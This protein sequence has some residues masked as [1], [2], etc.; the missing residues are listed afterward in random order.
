MA[1]PEY[2]KYLQLYPDAEMLDRESAYF[3]LGDC[4]R[5]MG[6]TNAAKNAYQNLLLNFA[7]GQF[8]GPAAY[9]LADMDYADKDYDGA[10]DYYRK[11]SVRLDDP[12]MVL[13][14]K[15][16]AARCLE[17]LKLPTDARMAYEDIVSTSGDNPYR[18]PSRLALAEILSTYG[19]KS[20]ALDQFLALAKEAKQPVVKAESYLEAGLLDVNDLDEPEKGAVDL[21][22]ALSYPE[23]GDE[24]P[25]A[26][27]GLLRVLAKEGKYKQ[28]LDQ[29]QTALD[30]VGADEKPQV[31]SLAADAKHQ[32]NDYAG[33]GALYDQIL[34]DYPNTVYSDEANVDK[35]VNLYYAKDPSL[36]SAID[37]YLA[38]NPEVSRRDKVTLLKAEALYS[39]GSYAAAAPVYASLEDSTLAQGYLSQAIYKLGF[40]YLESNQGANAVTALTKFM[41]DY[42]DD[43]LVPSALAT[44][45]VANLKTGDLDAALKDFNQL[46]T[47]YPEVRDKD[48][49]LALDKKALILGEQDDKAGMADAFQE[50]LK[51]Y[52]HSS[53][54]AEANYRI[55]DAAFSA[56]DYKACIEPLDAARKLNKAQYFERATV[57]IIAAY[58]TLGDRDALAGEVDLYE[59]NNPKD[60]VPADALRWLGDSYLDSNDDANAE[61]Y[62]TELTTRPEVSADDW[63]NLGK[64]QLGAQKY[65]DAI[66]SINRYLAPQNDPAMQTKGLLVLGRAQLEAGKLDDAQASADKA[67][68]LEPEG[69]ANAQGR[70][71]SGDIQMAR[72]NVEEAGKIYQ[73]I[74]VII[75]DPQ[76]T[77][78]A[79]EKAIDCLNQLGKTDDAAKLLNEL[80]T[81]YPEYQV[82]DSTRLAK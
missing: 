72:G 61:K 48:H 12:L 5:K 36:L 31:L 57:R 70:M 63:L 28:L 39:S 74:A 52:P 47:D 64:A 30:A 13:A 76:L 33:A 69:A 18:D 29:Y 7:I 71:L 24:K 26:A 82:K 58:Y 66:S 10:L 54:A 4:Y 8:V 49:E 6:N 60:K 25:L 1:A 45:G 46:L 38:T 44:R 79:M 20:D 14:S 75:D 67:C 11:A 21:N 65:D 81:K 22:K 9:R 27:M 3:Y 62:L 53:Y 51:E 34:K 80:E 68:T 50:L 40:C 56:K 77:P 55:G 15:F 43:K 41:N 42:P 78:K 2:E 16:Y 73:S 37:L 19:R 35:L 32:L 59:Q 17:A 23:L